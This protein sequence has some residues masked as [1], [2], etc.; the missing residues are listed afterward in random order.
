MAAGG[1]LE[2]VVAKDVMASMPRLVQSL[3]ASMT[4]RSVLLRPR[5]LRAGMV[6]S[7]ARSGSR[8][9]ECSSPLGLPGVLA[10]A[11]S[12]G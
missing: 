6:S 11:C 8:T 12:G 1:V 2:V 7:V 9:Q 4:L 10:P 5:R 3:I